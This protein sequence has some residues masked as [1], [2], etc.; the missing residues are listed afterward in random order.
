MFEKPDAPVLSR[1]VAIQTVAQLSKK[2]NL[3]DRASRIIHPLSRVLASGNSELRTVAMD[4]LC[5]LIYQLGKD[6][7]IFVP[8]INQVSLADLKIYSVG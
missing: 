4:T 6:Y 1:R 2:I 8:L 3:I 5:A 7:T